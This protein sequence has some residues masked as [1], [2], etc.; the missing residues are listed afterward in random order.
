MGP[1]GRSSTPVAC[2]TLTSTIVRPVARRL[3]PHHAQLEPREPQSDG[4]AVVP[5]EPEPVPVVDPGDA[6]RR[7]QELPQILPSPSGGRPP[8]LPE[9]MEVDEVEPAAGSGVRVQKK[10]T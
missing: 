9:P 2:R 6:E 7:E 4:L 8:M 10:M 5:P 3:D 1:P